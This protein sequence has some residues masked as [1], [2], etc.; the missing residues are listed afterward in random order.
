MEAGAKIATLVHNEVND[1][2]GE[3]EVMVASENTQQ[4]PESEIAIAI[5]KDVGNVT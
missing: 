2:V 4:G 3:K 1:A 5:D